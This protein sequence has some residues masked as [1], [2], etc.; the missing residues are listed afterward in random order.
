MKIDDIVIAN[1]KV[2]AYI[3]IGVGFFAGLVVG[4][5]L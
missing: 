2:I 4:L 3:N 1:W 5:C